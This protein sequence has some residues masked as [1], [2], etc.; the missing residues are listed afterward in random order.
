MTF[1]D[2][3][4]SERI[5]IFPIERNEDDILRIQT[6]VEKA[7]EYLQTIEDLHTNFNK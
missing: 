1:S 6:K 2:I 5:L 3:P 4:T 7:R